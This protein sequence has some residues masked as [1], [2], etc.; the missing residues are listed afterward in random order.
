MAD[1]PQNQRQ[2]TP[3]VNRAGEQDNTSGSATGEQSDPKGSEGPS[4][5]SPEANAASPTTSGGET[6]TSETQSSEKSD[7]GSA[8]AVGFGARGLNERVKAEAVK[9]VNGS[10]V[11][12]AQHEFAAKRGERK[13]E[14]DT[15]GEDGT[16]QRRKLGEPRVSTLDSNDPSVGW[17]AQH[18]V[19]RVETEAT[20]GQ[21]FA[22]E[23]LPTAEGLAQAGVLDAGLYLAAL[24]VAEDKDDSLFRERRDSRLGAHPERERGRV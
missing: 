7:D 12:K 22:V 23:E 9:K 3:F 13:S 21:V 8:Q 10:K 4:T 18:A 14:E 5:Q 6:Q 17:T 19:P 20:P 16:V 15:K 2:G 1:N 24:P 11:N